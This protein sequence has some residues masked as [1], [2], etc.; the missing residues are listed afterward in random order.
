M[1]LVVGDDLNPSISLNT[2]HVSQNKL[3]PYQKLPER[4]T[5]HKNK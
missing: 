1:T 4:L 5:Q 3:L 2:V